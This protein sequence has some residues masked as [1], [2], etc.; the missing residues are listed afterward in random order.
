[1]P[2]DPEPTH[3]RAIISYAHES[4]AHAHR[5]REFA[6]RLRYRGIACELDQYLDVPTAGWPTWMSA[7]IA[8][9]DSFVLV[10]PSEAYLRRW[11]LTEKESV[12]LGARWESK[13]IKQVLYE[14]E[15]FNKRVI[16]VLLDTADAKH[17]PIELRDTTR[18]DMSARGDE[19]RLL[20]R[21][22]NQPLVQPPDVG[23]QLRIVPEQTP[24][25]AA[26][27][28][29]LRNARAP[30]PAD[31]LAAAIGDSTSAS[32]PLQLRS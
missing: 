26:M 22:T 15:G 21:L 10:V 31:V 28:F 8:D 14:A 27:F 25:V 5:V 30:L 19:V 7:K 12:G 4:D 6:D 29:V 18:Y 20:A 2:K 1:M 17:I 9:S 32:T 11:T 3:V 16:P 13:L 24:I 23:S